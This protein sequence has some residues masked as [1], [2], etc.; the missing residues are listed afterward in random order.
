MF[1]PRR[2]LQ[3]R[4]LTHYKRFDGGAS[5]WLE[6]HF[7]LGVAAFVAGAAINVHADS[8][9]INLR[10]AGSGDRAYYIPSGGMFYYVSGANFFG[11]IVEWA[12]WAVASWSLPAAA[13][14]LFTLCNVGPR[15][16]Q[17]HAWY[18]AKFGALYPRRRK[19]VIPFVW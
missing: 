4:Y 8:V 15:G 10:R 19:A 5:A 1:R 9:L 17:H 13:F 14:A 12:G 11:E 3:G 6:P 18:R 7:I 16:A 2:Y